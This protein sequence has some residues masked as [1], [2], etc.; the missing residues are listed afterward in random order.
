MFL[1]LCI[2]FNPSCLAASSKYT[3]HIDHGAAVNNVVTFVNK[4]QALVTT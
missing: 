4:H 1:L 3:Q 2:C